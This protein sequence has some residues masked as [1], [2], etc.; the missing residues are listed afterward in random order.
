MAKNG[1]NGR[2]TGLTTEHLKKNKKWMIDQT[3][4]LTS[5]NVGRLQMQARDKDANCL[6]SLRIQQL[7]N[8]DTCT[9]TIST[10]ASFIIIDNLLT[11]YTLEWHYCIES[12]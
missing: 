10:E 6:W 1:G 8:L 7:G 9:E 3:M 11:M 4:M 12:Q 2:R 5:F